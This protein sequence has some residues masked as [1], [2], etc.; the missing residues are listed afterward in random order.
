M[1]EAH[2]VPKLVTY[3]VA[4]SACEQARQF[5]QALGLSIGNAEG[6]HGDSCDFLQLCHQF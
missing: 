1:Q 2:V 5:Q 3:A 6:S 4:V